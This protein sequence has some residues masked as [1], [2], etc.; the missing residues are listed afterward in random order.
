MGIDGIELYVSGSVKLNQS[1]VTDRVNWTTA[2]GA[3]NDPDDLLADLDISDAVQLQASGSGS[4]NIGDGA[5]VAGITDFSL[6][7]ATMDVVTGTAL[8]TLTG[9]DVE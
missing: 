6:N 1:P 2:T 3:A 4:L 5:V 8:G 7:I 9:A